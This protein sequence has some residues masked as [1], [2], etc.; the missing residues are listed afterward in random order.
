[1]HNIEKLRNTISKWLV[2]N[3]LARDTEF[4][5]RKEW[6][7]RNEPYIQ[8]AEL[9]LIFEGALYHVLYG[10]P[11]IASKCTPS[12]S[13]WPGDTATTSSSGMPGTWASIPPADV[14]R[15]LRLAPE[16][17]TQISSTIP[18]PVR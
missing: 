7:A 9:V 10:T 3:E 12:L 1:M 6:T 8:D 2:K 18:R 5:T 14:C 13:E 15:R 11:L 17:P 4:Y 16:M